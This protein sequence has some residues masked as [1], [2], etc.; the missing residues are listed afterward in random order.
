MKDRTFKTWAFSIVLLFTLVAYAERI[1]RFETVQADNV[2]V[3]SLTASTVPYANSSKRLTSSSVTPTE[4]GYLSGVTSALQTQ[5]DAKLDDFTGSTDNVILKSD[6]ASGNAVQESGILIDDSDN[7]TNVTSINS[8]SSTELSQLTNIDATTISSAQWGYLGALDQAL[9]TTDSTSFAQVTVDNLVVNGN[10]ISSSSGDITIS[11]TSEVDISGN[12]NILTQGDLRLQDTTGGEYIGF[13]APSTV[14][15]STLFTLPD[16]DGSSG[17]AIV[18]NGS[19]TLSWA[20]AGGGS[21]GKDYFDSEGDFEGGVSRATA[22]DD[23]GA[24]VDGTGGSPAAISVSQNST[25]P[26]RDLNDLDIAKAASD[27]SGEGVTLLSDSIERA[28]VGRALF[29]EAQVDSNH[30]NYTSGDVCINAYDVAGAATLPIIPVSGVDSD[31]C[32]QSVEG[33]VLVKILTTSSTTGAIRVSFHLASDSATASAWNIYVDDARLKVDAPIPV[34]VSHGPI[35][36]TP[37]WTNF[38]L[39]NGTVNYA[40]YERKGRFMIGYGLVTLGS[41]SSV[42]GNIQFTLPG[43]YTVDSSYIKASTD[44]NEFG[45]G[46]ALDSGTATYHLGV[47]Y[48]SST[49]LELF[50]KRADTTYLSSAGMG[51]T[52]PMTWATNDEFSFYFKIPITEWQEDSQVISAQEAYFKTV[53][54]YGSGNGGGSVTAS[55]TNIDFTEITDTHNAWNGTVF[56]APTDGR[57]KFNGNT[58]VTVAGTQIVSAYINGSAD[59]A[60]STNTST[61]LRPFNCTLDLSK[62]D[63]VSFRFNQ[64]KTLS[65]VAT[66]HWIQIEQVPN[67]TSFGAYM[68]PLKTQ[69]KYLAS[70][71]TTDAATITN[72]SFSGLETGKWY[73]VNTNVRFT[74]TAS[75]NIAIL[76]THNSSTIGRVWGRL[77]ASGAVVGGT[78]TLV[79]Q[80]AASTLTFVTNSLSATSTIEGNGT[81]DETW[82]QLSEVNPHVE[83]TGW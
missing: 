80:A 41:T 2:D 1:S 31:G 6:G 64:T 74:G 48:V 44:T 35:S 54:V 16:G 27:G 42:S 61:T 18:T 65:N 52:V 37:S 13:Q 62:G 26:L 71:F 19:G 4:L 40:Y 66:I 53:R 36:F 72:L 43:G 82:V 78:S 45:H 15:S 30:A 12:V 77:D 68:Q 28:D 81:K 70:D 20:N 58:T 9:A 39:G 7:I 76:I 25:T 8:V 29:F 14:T 46:R 79:F 59:L 38:S 55:T 11:P 75:D 10:D 23:A 24:Y 50:V 5:L 34:N 17:Q 67:I 21:G 83:Y 22:Y 63:Q 73:Q 51:A 56:T 3:S 33:V 60:C 49:D 57:Y 32:L 69:T 47:G